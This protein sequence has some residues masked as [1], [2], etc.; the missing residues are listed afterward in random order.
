MSTPRITL[1][2]MSHETN[3]FSPVITDLPRFSGRGQEPPEGVEALRRGRGSMSCLSGFIEVC[4]REGVPI[5]VAVSGVASPSGP[6]EDDAFEYMAERIVKAATHC[7]AML[8]EL[9]GAMVTRSHEDGEGELLRRIRHVAPQLPVGVALDMHANIYPDIVRLATLI[10][11]Y[12][13]YP[14]TDMHDTG[15]RAAEL[16]L[17]TLRGEIRPVMHWGNL[18]MLP[19][20]MRQ[21]TDD[22]PNRTL[23]ARAEALEAAA[24][25]GEGGALAVSVFTGFPHADIREAGLSVVVVDDGDAARAR[26][27]CEELLDAAWQARGAFVYPLEALGDSMARARAIADDP[28]TP[29]G[30]VVLLD[31]YDNSASGGTMDTTDVLAEI[32]RQGLED[33]AV[34]AIFDPEA[35]AAMV[36]AGVGNEVTL[37]LGGKT[38]M[39]SLPVQSAPLTVTGRVKAI[40]DGRFE[41][42]GE[43]NRIAG[44]TRGV[45]MDMGRA[46][47]LDTGKVEIVV[48]SHFLEPVDPGIFTSVGILPERKRYLMLKSRIHYRRGFKAMAKA[49]VECAG[50]G[51]CT[52]DYGQLRFENVRRPIYP[53][54]GIN[55]ADWREIQHR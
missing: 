37:A 9:H 17:R 32:L 50:V 29:P 20:V 40:V 28:T 16:L 42:V 4:E 36:A 8:L 10:T 55:A 54:D 12:H 31:H 1:A 25:R 45:T 6:V 23:Q 34:F 33:V 27:T 53:L 26:H 41:A 39:R 30:P 13:R 19:H 11:G 15:V 47:V 44:S 7:D 21:G 48:I 49:I 52:S 3:T 5:D 46:A 43:A 38:P 14:H 51:V 18:P 35:V 24:A 2:R 22:E